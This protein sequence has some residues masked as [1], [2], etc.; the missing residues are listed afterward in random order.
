MTDPRL[1]PLDALCD[2]ILAEYLMRIDQ[3]ERIDR[4]QFLEQHP[5]AANRLRSHFEDAAAVQH[6]LE[7][8]RKRM[9]ESA[10]PSMFE[11]TVRQDPGGTI[12]K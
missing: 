7:V 1:D 6:A 3:G 11:S 12:S 2:K 8:L 4:K 5:A 10:P 9:P